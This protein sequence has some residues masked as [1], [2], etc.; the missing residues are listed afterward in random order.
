M[1]ADGPSLLPGPLSLGS[2]EMHRCCNS[3]LGTASRSGP[4]LLH[5][6][7]RPPPPLRAA[8]VGTLLPGLHAPLPAPQSF[9]WFLFFAK[10]KRSGWRELQSLPVYVRAGNPNPNAVPLGPLVF[11]PKGG[12]WGKISLLSLRQT[13]LFFFRL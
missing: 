9:P 6:L 1:E 2:R 3:P 11:V 5:H 13:V 12:H 10:P 8:L 4:S 7:F